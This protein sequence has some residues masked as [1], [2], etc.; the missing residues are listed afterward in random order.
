MEKGLAKYIQFL[1]KQKRFY[2]IS[3]RQTHYN[4]VTI[5]APNSDPQKRYHAGSIYSIK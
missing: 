2:V 5:L 1:I 3:T 4:I